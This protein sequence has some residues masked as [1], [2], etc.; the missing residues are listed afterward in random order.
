MPV[1]GWEGWYEVSDLGRVR[2]MDRTIS[3]DNGQSRTHKSAILKSSSHNGYCTVT[4]CKEGKAKLQGIHRLVC[5]AFNGP[6]DKR[7]VNHLDGNK[8]NNT[9][10]NLQWATYTENQRHA[11]SSGLRRVRG[12]G[13]GRAKLSFEDV[14]AIRER[15]PLMGYGAGAKLAREYKVS[16][17]MVNLI[18]RGKN[19]SFSGILPGAKE[20]TT[21][22][23]NP[24]A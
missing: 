15:A 6:S 17:T 24:V 20:I 9:P 8:L 18:L 2:S 10:S 12:E 1:V 5:A 13:N 4:L 23:T 14:M 19:W 21:P 11:D 3:Y 22:I 16:T 7:T